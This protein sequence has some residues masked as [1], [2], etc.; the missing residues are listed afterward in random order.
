MRGHTL[1]E[2]LIVMAIIGILAGVFVTGYKGVQNLRDPIQATRT[3]QYALADASDRARMM[4]SDSAWGVE[5]TAGKIVT[6]SG[7]SYAARI[8]AN[9]KLYSLPSTVS[10]TGITDVLFAKFTGTPS[11]TGTTSFATA[12]STSSVIILP[13]GAFDHLP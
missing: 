2:L 10:T 3:Y 12:L 6:F 11:V 4:D 5:I 7:T 1:I 8:T 9:D 13:S